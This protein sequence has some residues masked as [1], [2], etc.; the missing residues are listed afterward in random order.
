[1]K[2]H[3][4]VLITGFA[5]STFS[6]AAETKVSPATVEELLKVAKFDQT[7]T[8]MW[9]QMDAIMNQAMQQTLAGKN[10]PP[11]AMQQAKQL[12]AKMVDTIKEDLSA[13]KMKEMVVSIYTEIFTEDEVRSIIDFYKTPGGQALIN[14]QPLVLQKTMAFMQQRMAAIVPKIQAAVEESVKEAAAGGKDK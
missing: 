2:N 3:F 6:V 5:L 12:S 1:M 10:L 13:E 14:K 4:L 7:M 8:A 9:G 11:E